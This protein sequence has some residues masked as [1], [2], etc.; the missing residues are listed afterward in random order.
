MENSRRRIYKT[1]TNAQRDLVL[2][3]SIE[4]A[5]DINADKGNRIIACIIGLMLTMGMRL[6]EIIS[7]LVNSLESQFCEELNRNGY[8]L[9]YTSSNGNVRELYCYEISVM[10]FRIAKDIH[11]AD[12]RVSSDSHLFVIY[13]TRTHGAAWFSAALFEHYYHKFHAQYLIELADDSG[14][15][16]MPTAHQ[17]RQTY[18]RSQLEFQQKRY[19][20][21]MT[22]FE[23]ELDDFEKKVF[24]E[25]K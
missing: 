19:R 23:V 25:N 16:I 11:D 5:N 1:L 8:Y 6:A 22:T 7:L 21:K 17:Y 12:N 9:K 13:N 24:C 3:K 20:G 10:F 2:S 18:L 15:S 14:Y 4:V